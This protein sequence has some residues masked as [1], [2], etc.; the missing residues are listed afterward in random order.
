MSSF[1]AELTA[2]LE[3]RNL[4]P[5]QYS[6]LLGHD[7]NGLVYNV[8]GG[9]K[10]VPMDELDDWLGALGI[11]PGSSEY[12]RLRRRAYE[13]YAPPHVLRLINQLTYEVGTWA[14]LTDQALRAHGIQ[15]PPLP[16]LWPDVPPAP[17]APK[18][19]KSRPRRAKPKLKRR[20]Q[21]KRKK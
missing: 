6:R 16:D 19:P 17:P 9:K 15:P 18:P 5:S 1:R 20:V 2:I 3:S 21:R 13:D 8:V 12:R 14:K 4:N 10:P 11:A 7:S